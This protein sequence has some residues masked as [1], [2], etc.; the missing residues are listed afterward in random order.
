ME[1]ET[2]I[3]TDNLE[4]IKKKLVDL[5]ANFFNTVI[6]EDDWF[7]QKGKEME[8]QRPGSY[9]LRIRKQGK[10]SFFTFKALTET[11]GAWIEHETGI[12]NPNDMQAILEKIGFK[13]VITITKE[14]TFG[15]LG[16][17]SICI[18][19]VKELGNYIEFEIISNDAKQAKNKINELLKKLNISE[20]QIEHR[21]YA[22]IIFQDMGVKFE[23]TQG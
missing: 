17:F 7:K 21:G 8:T 20:N 4:E 13:K 5:G 12:E 19:K 9:I 15:K 2:K 14:R 22:A 1:I 3:K 11:T 23:G 10:Q 16:E 18:D 6:Q